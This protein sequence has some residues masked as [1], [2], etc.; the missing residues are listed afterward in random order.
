M[1]AAFWKNKRVLLTGHTGFKGS[2]LALWLQE[3]G[4]ELVGYSLD[5]PTETNLYEIARVGDGM[6]SILGDIRNLQQLSALMESFRPEIVLHLAAQ[7][8]VRRSYLD[9]VETYTTNVIGTVNLLEA[10]RLC[11]SV[12]VV[13]NITTDKCYQNK[14]WHWGYRENEP[15]GG[16]DPYSSSKGCAELVT[17]A[18]RASF[19]S[20]SSDSMSDVRVAT[21]RAGNCIGGGDWGEDRLIP[22]MIRAIMEKRSVVIRNPVATRPWQYVLDPLHGYLVLAE[23]LW[24][25]GSLF[26][27][28]WNFG[29][30]DG[31]VQNVSW[32][33]DR[34]TALWKETA[35]WELDEDQHVH[36][37]RYLKLDSSKAKDLLGWETKLDVATTLQ[38]IVD[39]YQA[40]LDDQD[41][42]VVTR[43]Q[44][45]DYSALLSA[46]L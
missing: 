35:R 22:D 4:A 2:W 5:P 34:M 8:L 31:D 29:P 15:M 16:H 28:G 43:K 13:V 45:H 41:M 1:N 40:Y 44:I 20:S 32:I 42:Q 18:Y 3:M 26:A 27:G 30:G 37:A 21:A 17:S 33:A 7:A 11:G 39:W 25:E 9:P 23:K 38:C 36:E 24:Q 14:E 6:E 10:V 46:P 12:Q 19:F